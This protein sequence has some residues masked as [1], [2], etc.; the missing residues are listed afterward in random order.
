[1]TE[2]QS[3]N[4]EVGNALYAIIGDE[5]FLPQAEAAEAKIVLDLVG[6]RPYP[7]I[8]HTHPSVAI[9]AMAG[10]LHSSASAREAG[11]LILDAGAWQGD[12]AISVTDV[13][14]FI[15]QEG[16]E[17]TSTRAHDSFADFAPHNRVRAAA[18]IALGMREPADGS[19]T[20]EM[21]FWNRGG[22]C[23]L[24]NPA[25]QRH[26]GGNNAMLTR[27][28]ADE[29]L[30]GIGWQGSGSTDTAR[31]GGGFAGEAIIAD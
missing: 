27:D 19:E 4:K 28:L 22:V 23:L 8:H 16:L 18:E 6:T 9:A 17:A 20:S 13:E 10:G 15:Q 30:L 3:P 25:I 12:H 26:Y 29:R 7:L 14:G 31:Y 1:M 24:I 5:G 2:A 11:E 21:S